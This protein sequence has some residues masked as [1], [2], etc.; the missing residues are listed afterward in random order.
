MNLI[1]LILD[2]YIAAH[3]VWWF[4][5][6]TKRAHNHPLTPLLSHVCS[7]YCRLFRNV[8]LRICSKDAAVAVPVLSLAVV[9]LFLSIPF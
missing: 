9:R 7:P 6:E 2:L 8:E 4:L 3:A 1:I 5:Q